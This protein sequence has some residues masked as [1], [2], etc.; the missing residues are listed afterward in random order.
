VGLAGFSRGD[1]TNKGRVGGWRGAFRV[2]RINNA[3]EL[4]ITVTRENWES[5]STQ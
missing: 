3:Y 1:A 2:S 5:A 4:L